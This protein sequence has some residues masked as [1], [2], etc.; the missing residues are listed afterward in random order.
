MLTSVEPSVTFILK[1]FLQAEHAIRCVMAHLSLKQA[2][3]TSYVKQYKH[4]LINFMCLQDSLTCIY[5]RVFSTS[6]GKQA[7]TEITLAR[8]L[9][10]NLTLLLIG[11]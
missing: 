7:V 4:R 1:D 3:R 9:L 6:R 2:L 8:L 5:I 11:L 10:K